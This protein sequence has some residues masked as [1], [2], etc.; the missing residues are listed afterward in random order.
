MARCWD[1]VSKSMRVR[2][3]GVPRSKVAPM[4]ASGAIPKPTTPG[5]T[6]PATLSP[7]RRAKEKSV[8]RSQ[9]YDHREGAD[10]SFESAALV[11]RHRG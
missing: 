9:G 1:A 4:R 2:A 7:A 11:H 8:G 3:S 6:D 10:A 5:E